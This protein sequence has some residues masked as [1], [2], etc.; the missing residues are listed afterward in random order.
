[1]TS[2]NNLT[3]EILNGVLEAMRG[4]IPL[5]FTSD[6]PQEILSPVHQ[7]E[8]GVLIGIAGSVTGRLIIDGDSLIFAGLGQT[9]FGISLEGEMLASFVGE[10]GNMIAGNAATYASKRN[11]NI[12]ITPPTVIQGEAHLSGFGKAIC[13]LA[14]FQE[15]RNLRLILAIEEK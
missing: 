3:I 4:V 11:I 7:H 6:G 13:V 14:N 9:M 12:D 10:I 8:F 2:E 5:P 15:N 1:M